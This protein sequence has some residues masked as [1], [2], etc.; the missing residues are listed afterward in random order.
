M[1]WI[2]QYIILIVFWTFPSFLIENHLCKSQINV[3]WLK[4]DLDLVLKKL[5]EFQG[6]WQSDNLGFEVKGYICMV[7]T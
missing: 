1:F 5:K 4:K 3:C 2:L 7:L 6:T